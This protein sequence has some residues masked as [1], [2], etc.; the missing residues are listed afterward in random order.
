MNKAVYIGTHKDFK[1][2]NEMNDFLII[3]MG[4]NKHELIMNG[5]FDDSGDNI[6]KKNSNYSELT[7]EY[8]ILKNTTADIK[9]FQHYRRYFSNIFLKP[10]TL[11]KIQKD[12]EKVDA[13]LPAPIA[14]ARTSVWQYYSQNHRESDLVTLRQV[15][16]ELYPDYMVTFD[17]VM[18]GK[19][20]YNYNMIIAKEEIFNSYFSWL[21][22]ILFRLE[23]KVDISH[24]DAYQSRIFGFLSERLMNVWIQKNNIKFRT[25]FVINTEWTFKH[26]L[27]YKIMNIFKYCIFT[28][29]G[30]LSNSKIGD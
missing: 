5:F 9:G 16:V 13:I 1:V 23:E 11:K 4:P 27:S 19:F 30:I 26:N 24:L 7:A 17:K 14:M 12:L 28:K 2:P 18:N 3:K 29:F 10:L 6:S 20:S 8:W 22:K 21:F 25:R 15:I